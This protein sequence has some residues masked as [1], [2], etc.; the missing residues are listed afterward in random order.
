MR[1]STHP[2]EI[3]HE[4]FMLPHKL[5]ANA[6][7]KGIFVPLNHVSE[8]ISGQRGLTADTAMRLAVFFGNTPEFWQAHQASYDLSIAEKL[9]EAE[10]ADIKSLLTKD[11]SIAAA[12]RT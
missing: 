6:L 9:H 1:I 11:E 5:S 4:E 8:I 2:G 7:A 10:Y 3:L 12:K